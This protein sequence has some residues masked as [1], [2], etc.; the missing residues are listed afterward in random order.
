MDIQMPVMDGVE[1]CKRIKSLHPELPVVAVTANA[2]AA[3]VALYRE[4]GFDDYLSKP[5]EVGQLNAVLA[6]YLTAQAE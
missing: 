6:Q 4:E 3:D 5:V 2:M 1:A